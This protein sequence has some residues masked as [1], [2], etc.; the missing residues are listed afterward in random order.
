MESSSN[1]NRSLVLEHRCLSLCSSPSLWRAAVNYRWSIATALCCL[2]FGFTENIF[3]N[4]REGCLGLWLTSRFLSAVIESRDHQ[5][6]VWRVLFWWNLRER[7]FKD[8]RKVSR[9]VIAVSCC[10]LTASS[11]VSRSLAVV[12]ETVPKT[13]SLWHKKPRDLS[14]GSYICS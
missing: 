14:Y 10:R 3:S 5:V 8:K 13:N 9:P 2:V 12:I 7:L 1:N 4:L 11:L 6:L